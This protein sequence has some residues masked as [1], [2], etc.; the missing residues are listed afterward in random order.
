MAWDEAKHAARAAWQKVSGNH[1]RLIGCAV[2]DETGRKI[3]DVHNLWADETGQLS[4]IGVKTGWIF[5]KN[6]VVPVHTSQVNERQ[7]IIRLPFS[8]E[9]IKNAPTFDADRDLSDSA[10]NEIYRYYGVT[11]SEYKRQFI[12]PLPAGTMQTTAPQ[13]EDIYTPLRRTDA[14]SDAT[15]PRFGATQEDRLTTGRYEPKERGKNR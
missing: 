5:G 1:E 2:H 15:K 11:R 13:G 12:Q 6:H 9:K 10:E 14:E 7:R 3:G 4:F 8:E